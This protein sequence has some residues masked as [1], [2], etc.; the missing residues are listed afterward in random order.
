[1]KTEQEIRREILWELQSLQQLPPLSEQTMI[2]LIGDKE[3]RINI[4]KEVLELDYSYFVLPGK[5]YDEHIALAVAFIS[6][7][8]AQKERLTVAV[9]L[10]DAHCNRIGTT[11][12]WLVSEIKPV[13]GSRYLS[14]VI[15]RQLFIPNPRLAL[16]WETLGDTFFDDTGKPLSTYTDDTDPVRVQTINIGWQN[17][18]TGQS[19]S[20]M[21]IKY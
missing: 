4:L 20:P 2:K 15:S 10:F 5:S 11:D 7:S 3:Y 18:E 1:M 6:P 9:E 16:D 12:G 21:I 17:I 13:P 19:Y 14:K 8:D